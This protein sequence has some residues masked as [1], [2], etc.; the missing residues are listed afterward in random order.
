MINALSID[1]ECWWCN[2]FLTKYL[3]EDKDDLILE[4]LNPLLELLDKYDTK[5]TFF[6]LGVIAE[7]YPEIIED[8]HERG[9]EIACHAYSHDTLYKLGP[10]E[11]E[12]EI[13]KSLNLL[14]K[15]NP[16]GFRAPSFSVDNSTKWA[17]EILE[18]HGFKYDSSIFPIK[19]MIYGVPNAP[20]DI[21]TPSKKDVSRHG[22]GKIIE[23][24][25]TTVRIIKNFPIA[26]GFYLRALP[27]WFL[28]WG[29]K[30]V[31]RKRPAIIY[32]HPWETYPGVPRLKLPPFSRFEAYYGIPSAL[33]KL[34]A[35]LR[36]FKFAPVKDVLHNEL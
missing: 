36:E 22:N 7:K 30:K 10:V 23:F 20:V 5:A 35:L 8:L 21:Y 2:E 31:N 26:G 1:L 24:P 6:V 4:S 25:L 16:I 17:F 14:A 3:P 19:T 13:K 27:L 11:F 29:I 15:Y 18:R 33:M 32:I 28:K 12:N 9:H 34:E